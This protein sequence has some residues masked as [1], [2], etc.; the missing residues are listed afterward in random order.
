M[1]K[2]L[3]QGKQTILPNPNFIII[4]I[5]IAVGIVGA[6]DILSKGRFT[7]KDNQHQPSIDTSRVCNSPQAV[8]KPILHAAKKHAS[9]VFQATNKRHFSKLQNKLLR[10]VCFKSVQ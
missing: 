10:K 1:V 3:D 5:I 6:I 2:Q 7:E 8:G 4:I 9:V